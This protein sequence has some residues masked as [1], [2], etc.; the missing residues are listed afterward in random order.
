MLDACMNFSNRQDM[1]STPSNS[2]NAFFYLPT[3]AILYTPYAMLSKQLGGVLIRVLNLAL[4]GVGVWRLSLIILGDLAAGQFWLISILSLPAAL[5]S[6]RNGQFDL[7]LAGLILN[8]SAAVCQKRLWQATFW[9]CYGFAVKPLGLVPLLLFGAI[10]PMLGLRMLL[11]VVLAELVPWLCADWR[12]VWWEHRRLIETYGWAYHLHES[13]FSDLGA[14]L[15]RLGL[16]LPSFVLTGIRGCSSLACVGLSWQSTRLL[17]ERAGWFIGALSAG[18]L[19]LFNPRSEACSFVYLSPFFA[20]AAAYCINRGPWFN[21]GVILG[22][23]ALC[24]A[25]DA[26]PTELGDIS[27]GHLVI[28]PLAALVGMGLLIYLMLRREPER[29]VLLE[30]EEFERHPESNKNSIRLSQMAAK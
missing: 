25:S 7:Q 13:R 12:Y 22:G 4:Y 16:T 18:F 10:Y 28:K 29:T 8:A 23:L 17:E 2:G 24:L 19:V 14:M 11:G 27:K 21:L 30:E 3:S 15:E 20:I 5:A 6:L 26:V 1:Y 9:L